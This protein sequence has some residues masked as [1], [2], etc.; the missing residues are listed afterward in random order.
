MHDHFGVAERVL[1]EQVFP[2]SAPV[3]ATRGLVG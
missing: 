2:D 1:A 3:K